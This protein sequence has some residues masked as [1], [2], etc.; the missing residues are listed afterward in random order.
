MLN[1]LL[2]KDLA[3][4]IHDKL[5][6]AE[7]ADQ[8]PNFHTA[9]ALQDEVASILRENYGDVAGYKI[10]WNNAV[11]IAE[12]SPNAPAVGHIFSDQVQK[13]GVHF[14]AGSFE[15]LVVEPE[16]IAVIGHDI[17]GA[18]QTPET[19]LPFIAAFHAGFEIMD[20]RGSPSSVQSH[21]PSI[22]ANNIFNNGL[23]IANT[24]K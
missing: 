9:Y 8:I 1:K 19:V 3:Q 17:T 11:Q 21:P 4:R 22:V 13:S 7:I 6:G 15:Q 2:T 24:M 10:A 16:I 20:R 18:E 5:P 23:V 14:L 12:L